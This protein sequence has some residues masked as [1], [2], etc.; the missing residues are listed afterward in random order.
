MGNPFGTWLDKQ[1]ADYGTAVAAANSLPVNDPNDPVA[2]AEA[3]GRWPNGAPYVTGDYG[4]DTSAWKAMNP[5]GS[6]GA[7]HFGE[8]SGDTAATIAQRKAEADRAAA[9]SEAEAKRDQANRD[10]AY[11]LS[12]GDSARADRAQQSSDYWQGISAQLK[13]GDQALTSRGQDMDYAAA[14]ARVQADRQDSDNRFKVGMAGA[15]NDAERNTIQAKWNAEQAQIAKME[16]ETKRVLGGQQNQ[17]GQFA[18]ET[19]RAASMG[20]LALD[21]NKFIADEA[22][23][24]H[25][26]WSLFFTQRGMAPD[27]NTMAAGGTPATGAALAPSD[28]MGAYKP[29]TLPPVFTGTP[30][31]SQA[32]AVGQATA[33]TPAANPFITGALSGAGGG[34]GG[35]I[36]MPTFAPYTAPKLDVT[37]PVYAPTDI[38]PG[39]L[40]GGVPLA[41]LKPGLNLSTVGGQNTLT[42]ADFGYPTYYDAGKT[43]QVGATD[44][45]N[46]GSQVYVDYPGAAHA[47]GG[48]VYTGP[49]IV[50]DSPDGSPSGRE[51]IATPVMT[52]DG[53]PG[54]HVQPINE[55]GMAAQQRAQNPMT[56]AIDQLW[57]YRAKI[58]N[59]WNQRGMPLNRNMYR[60]MMAADFGMPHFALGT[61]MPAS[62]SGNGMGYAWI[63]ASNNG[64]LAGASLPNRLKMLADAG[65][66]IGPAVAASA[67]GGIAGG[68]NTGAAVA[69]AG[70]GALP[71]LQQMGRMTKSELENTRGYYDGPVGVAP[72]ADIVDFLGKTTSHLQS[73]AQSRGV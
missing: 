41:G 55:Q 23:N 13:Q 58:A 72:W 61:D 54:M 43:R 6:G 37:G 69:G 10:R 71:S 14:M 3:A 16:D 52:A 5:T 39:G 49:A 26:I 64:Q 65:M 15:T 62:Y 22:S 7:D 34:G 73:A 27:W 35:A 17:T 29:T 2:K 44:V 30:G 24:P 18:A 12:I 51:E 32:A 46:P 36:Q 66:P 4:T 25:N 57:N 48:G 45:V 42:G 28:V 53:R 20:R 8:V 31:N 60:S 63:P 47:A 9:F 19:D 38:N 67:T 1:I 56:R 40:Q 59:Q 11:A 33:Y 68:L 70:G 50:G 21:N